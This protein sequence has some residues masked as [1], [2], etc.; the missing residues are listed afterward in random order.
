MSI[1]NQPYFQD[2][3]AAYTKL[4]S[5]LWADGIVGVYHHVSSAH[6]YRYVT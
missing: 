6:L 1:L 3:A 4:E 5:I 2:E